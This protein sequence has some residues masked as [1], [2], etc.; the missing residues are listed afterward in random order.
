MSPGSQARAE[1]T[2]WVRQLRGLTGLSD[3]ECHQEAVILP[4][5]G[6]GCHRDWHVPDPPDDTERGLSR[7]QL[8]PAAVMSTA[9]G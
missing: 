2:L 5:A 4:E 6:S 1:A 3:T 9:A 8:A 7:G